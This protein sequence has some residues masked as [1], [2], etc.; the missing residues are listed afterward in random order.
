MEGVVNARVLAIFGADTSGFRRG[1]QQVNRDTRNMSDRTLN[2]AKDMGMMMTRMITMPLIALGAA[3]TNASA[4]FEKEMQNVASISSE[5]AENIREVSM[6]VQNFGAGTSLG[7]TEAAK[8]LYEIASAG[9]VE[10]TRALAFMKDATLLAEAGLSDMQSTAKALAVTMNALE[11]TGITSAKAVDVWIRTV[12]LGVGELGEF[13]NAQ[14]Y[15]LPAIAT[16]GNKFEEGMAIWARYTQTGAEPHTAARGVNRMFVSLLKTTEG[17]QKILDRIKPGITFKEI[18]EQEGSIFDGLVKIRSVMKDDRELWEMPVVG[19]RAFVALTNDITSTRKALD[20]FYDGLEGAAMSAFEQQSKTFVFAMKR[21][22]SE[23]Q[24]VLVRIGDELQKTAKPFVQGITGLFK[25]IG[26]SDNS[27]IKNIVSSFAKLALMGPAMYLFGNSI[28]KG[29]TKAVTKL[30]KDGIPALKKFQF[31]VNNLYRTIKTGR[32]GIGT[33]LPKSWYVQTLFAGNILDAYKNKWRV[34]TRDFRKNHTNIRGY[35]KNLGN[36]FKTMASTAAISLRN[37]VKSWV[38][39]RKELLAVGFGTGLL[40]GVINELD[41]LGPI[42]ADKIKGILPDNVIDFLGLQADKIPKTLI[43]KLAAIETVPTITIA[44]ILL[45]FKKTSFTVGEKGSARNLWEQ[46]I[47]AAVDDKFIEGPF[48]DDESLSPLMERYNNYLHWLVTEGHTNRLDFMLTPNAVITIDTVNMNPDMAQIRGAV[49]GMMTTILGE[50]FSGG[51]IFKVGDFYYEMSDAFKDVT[52]NVI[53]DP[54]ISQAS[55]IGAPDTSGGHSLFPELQAELTR[56]VRLNVLQASSSA[57]VDGAIEARQD[58]ADNSELW[59]SIAS[60]ALT[61][62]IG[63]GAFLL[64]GG[65][66]LAGILAAQLSM[67]LTSGLIDK[68]DFLGIA[69]TFDYI[70]AF[71]NY[72]IAR[73][74]HVLGGISRDE[75]GVAAEALKTSI[76][77][78]T[79][80]V[81]DQNFKHYEALGFDPDELAKFAAEDEWLFSEERQ[82]LID[83]ADSQ[84]NKDFLDGFFTTYT[85]PEDIRSKFFPDTPSNYMEPGRDL[86]FLELNT[87][88]HKAVQEHQLRVNRRMQALSMAGG[89]QDIGLGNQQLQGPGQTNLQ[90]LEML[91]GGLDMTPRQSGLMAWLIE[92]FD[93]SGTEMDSV[94]LALTQMGTDTVDAFIMGAEHGF[95]SES[96]L[97]TKALLAKDFLQAMYDEFKMG[98][99]SQVMIN[100]GKEVANSFSLGIMTNKNLP[101]IAAVTVAGMMESALIKFLVIKDNI[102]DVAWNWGVAIGLGLNNGLA[103]IFPAFHKTI[104]AFL[105]MIGLLWHGFSQIVSGNGMADAVVEELKGIINSL[106]NMETINAG[107]VSGYTPFSQQLASGQAGAAA[108]NFYHFDFNS[109]VADPQ[110]FIRFYD[111]ARRHTDR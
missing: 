102:S 88:W 80:G 72:Q 84:K 38:M 3:A 65:N 69:L 48:K 87:E 45:D 75:L 33:F 58:I 96:W 46:I 97:S 32:S 71:L 76:N 49:G 50:I 39:A 6:E 90:M 67:S 100:M 47:E 89:Y 85:L 42:I 108:Q 20:N 101:A 24:R 7:Q 111:E 26:E 73:L 106:N 104:L 61:G 31:R 54:K 99:P 13:V 82:K 68:M 62:I 29:I 17:M 44:E 86:K 52:A 21:M 79:G 92:E 34:F 15:I 5:M 91:Q 63:A 56:L 28:T 64:T 53:I 93:L 36:S 23:L 40:L 11:G 77:A 51:G 81:I 35:L 103:M 12:Q 55:G 70:G 43:E 94:L 8:A 18:I 57:L 1:L 4:K 74:G 110:E 10:Q 14:K 19:A 16:F 83:F 2:M 109:L 98:S 105:D 9:I 27:T 60:I 25:A 41:V 95:I 78:Y 22:K 107:T 59:K 37:T 30:S 66:P